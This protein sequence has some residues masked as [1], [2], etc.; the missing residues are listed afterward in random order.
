MGCIANLFAED[1]FPG[2]NRGYLNQELR[3]KSPGGPGFDEI[4][5]KSDVIMQL[6]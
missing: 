2:D 5:D 4:H 3:Y 1:I 6:K